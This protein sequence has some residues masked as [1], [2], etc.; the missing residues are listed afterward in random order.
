MDQ[1][2]A[3]AQLDA[4]RRAHRDSAR[5]S[6]PIAVTVG[7]AVLAGVGVALLGRPDAVAITRLLSVALLAAAYLL[8]TLYRTRRGLDGYQGQVRQTNIV[9][10][11]SFVTLFVCGLNAD[12]TLAVVYLVFGIVVAVTYFFA[13]RGWGLPK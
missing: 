2:E 13:L 12:T 4:V 1:N 8:P 3:R 9:W 6:L 7:A 11:I 10:S 5:P